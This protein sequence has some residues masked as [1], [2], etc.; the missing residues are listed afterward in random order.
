MFLLP[1]HSHVVSTQ[2]TIKDKYSGVIHSMMDNMNISVGQQP[3]SATAEM[4]SRD[5]DNR[6][7]MNWVSRNVKV[8]TSQL[9]FLA[10]PK[11]VHYVKAVQ[12]VEKAVK[13]SAEATP[14]AIDKM[15]KPVALSAPV[16]TDDSD[17]V[18]ATE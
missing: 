14:D 7:Q 17:K 15:P 6:A 13:K 4:V 9:M 5:L 1:Y 10:S 18:D 12:M 2:N 16:K 3:T 8:D 11:T